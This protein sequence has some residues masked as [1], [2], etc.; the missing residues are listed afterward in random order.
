MI[1]TFSL[2]RFIFPFRSRLQRRLREKRLNVDV[3]AFA[4]RF[5]GSRQR[6]S[7]GLLWD[8]LREAA[9]VPDFRPDPDDSLS[10]VYAKGPEE[11]WDD[12]IVPLLDKLGVSVSGI[13]FTRFNFSSVATPRDVVAFV[14]KVAEAGNGEGKRQFVD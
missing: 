2:Y 1:D 10:E 3:D 8:L 9:F 4:R 13:D 7:A 11:V 6:D 12:V 14:M 5:E